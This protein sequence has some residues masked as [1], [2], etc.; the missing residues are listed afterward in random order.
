MNARAYLFWKLTMWVFY[1]SLL[2]GMI[3][4][5]AC[6]T[7]ETVTRPGAGPGDISHNDKRIAGVT[8]CLEQMEEAMRDIEPFIDGT[9]EFKPGMTKQEQD[10]YFI[11]RAGA[12]WFWNKTKK[13]CWKKL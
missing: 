3:T 12:I 4:V 1:V 9:R 5:S 11:D 8:T 7:A 10:D 6:A 13:A 2:T